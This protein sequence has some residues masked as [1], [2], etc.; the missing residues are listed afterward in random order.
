ML[1]FWKSKCLWHL[2][3]RWVVSPVVGFLG[4]TCK[5]DEL[6]A[7]CITNYFVEYSSNFNVKRSPAILSSKENPEE[8]SSGV[9]AL[10]PQHLFLIHISCTISAEDISALGPNTAKRP[11]KN[12][13]PIFSPSSSPSCCLQGSQY[14]L[15]AARLQI[16]FSFF[17]FSIFPYSLDSS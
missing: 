5:F 3:C 6:K 10:L 16:H 1:L 9:R 11:T 7:N 2:H 15:C 13:Y 14:I 17:S 4:E 8:S 12:Q